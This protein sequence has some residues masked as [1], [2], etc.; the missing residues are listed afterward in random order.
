[1]RITLPV[2]CSWYLTYLE[3][4]T[5]LIITVLLPINVMAMCGCH[6]NM[7]VA[8]CENLSYILIT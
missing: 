2:S 7:K 3:S 4:P 5:K 8:Y 1:M 6:I